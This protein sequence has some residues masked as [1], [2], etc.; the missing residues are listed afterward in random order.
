MDT[1]LIGM[2]HQLQIRN[3]LPFV[4]PG[5]GLQQAQQLPHT[6]VDFIPTIKIQSTGDAGLKRCWVCIQKYQHPCG[7]HTGAD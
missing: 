4:P 2:Y 3:L 1:E 5:H 6:V 7:N